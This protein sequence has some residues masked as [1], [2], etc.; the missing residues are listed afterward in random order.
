M[1]EMMKKKS[2]IK[3]KKWLLSLILISII[4][5][6]MFLFI[7]YE[8]KHMGAG[9]IDYSLK[10]LENFISDKNINTEII[11]YSENNRPL[12]YTELGNI[13]SKYSILILVRQH[14][15]ETTS[16]FIGEGLINSIL[17][18]EEIKEKYIFHIFM[19][20]NPDGVEEG[21][22]RFNTNWKDLNRDWNNPK[23]AEI[24]NIQKFINKNI[25]DIDLVLD[26]HA[27]NS[28]NKY[29]FTQKK[30][31]IDNSLFE[32]NENLINL[33]QKIGI[34]NHKP[35]YDKFNPK[36]A[37]SYFIDKYN[38]SSFTYEVGIDF[39]EENKTKIILKLNVIG[40]E[41]IYFVDDAF[42]KEIIK[43]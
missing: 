40:K 41:L 13:N 12:Y 11:G 20:T 15:E 9:T 32:Q 33:M 26:L 21:I 30:G 7:F 35:T 14:P 28:N 34:I 10:D 43:G 27:T 16:S 22:T 18:N 23:T 1:G 24:I 5:I 17:T 42:E 36:I 8:R 3:Q 4:I 25:N 38:I 37:K 29:V 6:S 2:F 19:M 31:D 39:K